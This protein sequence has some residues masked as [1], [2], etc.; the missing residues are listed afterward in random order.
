MD[1]D[2]ATTRIPAEPDTRYA[3]FLV[4]VWRSDGE[5]AW[6]VVVE[7]VGA[8]DRRAFTAWDELVAYVRNAVSETAG[9]A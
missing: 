3:A 6:R 2:G 8:E 5:D 1:T 4:R 9:A 7:R